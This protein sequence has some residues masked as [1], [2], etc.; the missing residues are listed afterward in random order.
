MKSLIIP[1]AGQS[2]RFP[3]TR[4]K[5]MLTHPM[6]GDLMCVESLKGIN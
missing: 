6:S 3:D 1:M 2:S 4:P 5:W